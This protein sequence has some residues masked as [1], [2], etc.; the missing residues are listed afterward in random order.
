MAPNDYRVHNAAALTLLAQKEYNKAATA[1]AQA[2]KLQPNPES[3][4]RLGLALIQTS[5]LAGTM[6]FSSTLLHLT[7]C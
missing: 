1:C 4:Y 6:Q 3:Y 5:A 2:I 7:N